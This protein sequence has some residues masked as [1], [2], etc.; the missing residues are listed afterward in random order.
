MEKPLVSI[1]NEKL[2]ENEKKKKKSVCVCAR[3][4]ARKI[5]MAKERHIH[6]Y[7]RKPKRTNKLAKLE[8]KIKTT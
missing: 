7:P 1:D 6:A 8:R 4:R 5:H 3:A 2:E